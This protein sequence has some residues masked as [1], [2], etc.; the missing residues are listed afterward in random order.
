VCIYEI[1]D[2]ILSQFIFCTPAWCIMCRSSWIDMYTC[3]NGEAG[4]KITYPLPAMLFWWLQ[5][6]V[7]KCFCWT[8]AL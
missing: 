2:F 5:K 4:N 6:D 1:I 3:D 8:Q 7:Q